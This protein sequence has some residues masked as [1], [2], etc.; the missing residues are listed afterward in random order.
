MLQK[1]G[2]RTGASQE[3]MQ[4]LTSNTDRPL[5]RAQLANELGMEKWQVSNAINTLAAKFPQVERPVNGIYRWNSKVVE[6]P[7]V[8]KTELIVKVV[9]RKADGTL[10]VTDETSVYVMRKLDW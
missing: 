1:N 4:Y 10:L 8:P 3:V 7:Q 9:D 2:R 6:K 5:I